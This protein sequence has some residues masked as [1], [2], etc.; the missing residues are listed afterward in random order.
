MLTILT[1]QLA[2]THTHRTPPPIN[3]FNIFLHLLNVRSG[4]QSNINHTNSIGRSRIEFY[5]VNAIVIFQ[6]VCF[7]ETTHRPEVCLLTSR[8]SDYPS[9]SN[10]KTRIPGVNDGDE[11]ETTDVSCVLVGDPIGA[12]QR[13]HPTNRF[14]QIEQFIAPSSTL[15]MHQNKTQLAFNIHLYIF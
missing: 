13:R 12:Y 5:R 1:P 3:P 4:R 15:E 7:G 8:V 10:G 14:V 2:L 6:T 11:F 9:I